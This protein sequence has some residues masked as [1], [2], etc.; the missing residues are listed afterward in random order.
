MLLYHCCGNLLP[1]SVDSRC[2]VLTDLTISLPRSAFNK[3][4]LLLLCLFLILRKRLLFLLDILIQEVKLNMPS[5][6]ILEQK[7]QIVAELTEKLKD[8]ISGVIVEYKGITVDADTKLR[9]ELREA[10]VDYRVVKNTLLKRAAQEAGI[11]GFEDVLEGTTAIAIGTDY[12]SAARIINDYIEKSRSKTYKIK[13]GYYE[14][15]GISVEEVVALAKI[16]SKEALL[17]QLACALNEGAH[18]LAVALNARAEQLEN[19]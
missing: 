6:A 8:S 7:Q 19:A 14:G 18:M 12:T 5:K 10:G 1:S 13:A 16:P 11:S 17:S 3:V 9:R 2:F 4:T 15:K